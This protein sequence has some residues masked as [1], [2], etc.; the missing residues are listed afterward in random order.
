MLNYDFNSNQKIVKRIDVI[1]CFHPWFL[2][3]STLHL[4]EEEFRFLLFQKLHSVAI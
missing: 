2:D 3:S 4:E 1:S